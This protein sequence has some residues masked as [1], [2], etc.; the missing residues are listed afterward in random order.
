[1]ALVD[2]V[3]GI[4]DRLRERGIAVYRIAIGVLFLTHGAATLFGVFGGA[5]SN[6]GHAADFASWP[7]WWAGLIQFAGGILIA[8]GIG[9]RTAAFV[10]SG[11]MAYAY[12]AVHQPKALLPLQNGGTGAAVFTWALLVLVFTGPGAWA[13][14]AARGRARTTEQSPLG[15]PQPHTG[16]G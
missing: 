11:A 9:T 14:S 7:D 8:L 2:N 3:T 6:P 13:L 4:V 12:F 5:K 15:Q 16:A 10:S 1:M